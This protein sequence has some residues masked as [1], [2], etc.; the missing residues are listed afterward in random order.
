MN[1]KPKIILSIHDLATGG[2]EKVI[3]TEANMLHERGYDVRLVTMLKDQHNDLAPLLR[4]PRENF[5]QFHFNSHF[6][7]PELFKLIKFLKLFKPDIVISASLFNNTIFK[8][9]K[10]FYPRFRLIIRE[11]NIFIRH[12]LK[13][14]LFDTFTSP[15][16]SGYFVDARAIKEDMVKRLKISGGKITVIYNGIDKSSFERPPV[17]I[18]EKRRELGIPDDAFVLLNVGSMSTAQKGQEYALKAL[19]KISKDEDIRLVFAGDGRRKQK[20]MDEAKQL[21]VSERVLFLGKRKDIAELRVISDVFV[22]PSLWE[23]MP[24][25]MFDAMASGMP[26]VITLVGGVA[27]ILT[28]SQSALFIK[29]KDSQGIVD[30][31]LKLKRDN[32]L[33]KKIA[34]NAQQEARRDDLTWDYHIKQLEKLINM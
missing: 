10:L 29:P 25:A 13:S 23:G 22:F 20:L 11:G 34:D 1:P 15:L 33:R 28:D 14:R 9:A 5:I 16:V 30:M 27:E 4:I 8:F 24:N 26:I 32:N 2:S 3:V 12:S 21:G 31:V 19:A 17:S 18:V 7:W 6:D